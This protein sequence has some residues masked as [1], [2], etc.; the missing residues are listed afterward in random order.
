MKKGCYVGDIKDHDRVRGIFCVNSGRILK[1]K[2]GVPYLALTLMD[3]TGTIEARLWDIPDTLKDVPASGSFLDIEAEAQSFRDSVQ[4]KIDRIFPVNDMSD[5]PIEDFLPVT[6]ANRDALWA[7]LKAIIKEVLDPTL[8]PLIDKI[9]STTGYKREFFRAPAGKQIHHAYLGGLLEHTVGVASLA[10]EVLK[11][12]TH[13]DRNLLISGALVHDLGKIKEFRYDAPPIDYTDE[14]RLLGHLVIGASLLDDISRVIGLDVNHPRILALKHLVLSHHGERD[15]GA[16]VEPMTEE[17]VILYLL[18][19]M[20]A[21]IN[22]MASLR[23]ELSE[24][25][26]SS[27]DNSKRWTGFQR[28]M[29]RYLFLTPLERDRILLSHMLGKN[30]DS[31]QGNSLRSDIQRCPDGDLEGQPSLWSVRKA[32]D[33]PDS[34]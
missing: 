19:D 23:K 8:R 9:F 13:L 12:Y 10:I 24:T 21:K 6:N 30:T 11:V 31:R 17:A 4:L 34:N 14:G 22:Y 7:R 16:A 26:V 5:I 27:E 3:K 20:D 32:G 15:F 18:D 25:S 33:E 28:V 29:G 2:N 1:T